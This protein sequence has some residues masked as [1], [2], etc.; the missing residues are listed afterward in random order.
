[1]FKI[2]EQIIHITFNQQHWNTHRETHTFENKGSSGNGSPFLH[3]RHRMSPN[4]A[5]SD[6]EGHKNT[7]PCPQ[8][9]RALYL[10]MLRFR[11]E[12]CINLPNHAIIW[13]SEH[14]IRKTN[15]STEL[16]LKKE[17]SLIYIFW[18]S[19][20]RSTRLSWQW[21]TKCSSSS[22]TLQDIHSRWSTFNLGRV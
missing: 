8:R 17:E 19:N 9:V 21:R 22:T 12:W 18:K 20:S 15:C 11:N 14:P 16:K 2:I 7:T 4:I 6:E 5:A 3:W 10:R 13:G 1:M